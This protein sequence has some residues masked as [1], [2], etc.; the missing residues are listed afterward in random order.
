MTSIAQGVSGAAVEV[1]PTDRPGVILVAHGSARSGA[2]SEPVLALVRQ[3]VAQG[4]PEVRAAFWK[5]EPFLDQALDATRSPRLVVLP[6]F[7][8]EGYF[9]REVVPREVGVPYGESV[10]GGRAVRLLRPLG[11]DSAID[12]LVLDRGRKALGNQDSADDALLV[13]LG[14]GTPRDPGSQDTVLAACARLGLQEA[15]SRV[16]PAF[17]DVAPRVDEVVAHAPERTVVV[18]PFLVASGY[19]GGTTVPTDLEMVRRSGGQA[20]RQIR[21]AEPVGTHPALIGLIETIVLGASGDFGEQGGGTTKTAPLAALEPV[22]AD[23]VAHLGVVTFLEVE[24]CTDGGDA[25][26]LRHAADRG[27]VEA[28]L[29]DLTDRDALAAHTRRN[30]AGGHRPLR[31]AADLPRGW[32]YHAGGSR[33]LVEALVAIYGPAV[34]HWYL[35]EQEALPAGGFAEVAARQTGIYAD[36]QQVGAES[37]TAGIRACCEGRPCLRTRLWEAAGPRERE[38]PAQ[39]SDRE[40]ESTLAVPC[41]TPCPTLLGTVLDLAS[42]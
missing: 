2:S 33:A 30:A 29:S 11:T 16:V 3:L 22:L 40:Q 28:E 32:R 4:F 27:M 26:S 8:A 21:Y 18:V 37:V 31:T 24:I 10:H 38:A 20:T 41:P 42:P 5:E 12:R 6:I 35:G 19:H 7:L 15:F 1:R 34:V 36:L 17:I 9:G 13:I 25:F 39:T 23:R 14:H